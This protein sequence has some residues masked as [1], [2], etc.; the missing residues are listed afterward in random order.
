MCHYSEI[1]GSGGVLAVQA[2][3]AL[4]IAASIAFWVFVFSRAGVRLRPYAIPISLW[5]LFGTLDIV[6]TAKG[7]FGEPLREGN[8]LARFVFVESGFIGPV[9]ASVLWV[10]LWSSLILLINRRVKE[11][12]AGFISLAIFY[13]LAS[14]HLFGFSSWFAPLCQLSRASWAMLPSWSLRLMGVILLG[15]AIAGIHFALA[16]E[17]RK[18][19]FP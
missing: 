18:R 3:T 9:V 13:S 14:G 6:I 2:L 12:P 10:A 11:A 17:I 1:L 15:C 7:T 19:K 4:S 5:V 16:G 8:P